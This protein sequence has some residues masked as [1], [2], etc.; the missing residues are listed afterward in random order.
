MGAGRSPC[1]A[2]CWRRARSRTT[3]TR[4]AATR[5]HRPTCPA[6]DPTTTDPTTGDPSRRPATPSRPCG[7]D[8]EVATVT[9]PDPTGLPSISE[10]GR[11]DRRRDARQRA[12]LHRALERQSRRPG[13]DAAGG[14]RRFGR[15]DRRPGRRGPFPRTHAVQRHRGVP[16]ER[17]HRHAAQLRGE[18]RRRRE[19][20]HELRRDGL[21]ADDAH[22]GPDRGR[23]RAADPRTMAG[24]GHARSGA[25]RGR[26]WRRA[27]RV[28][29]VGDEFERPHL[30]RARI[31]APRRLAVRGA[32]PDRHRH[33]DQRDDPRAAA[34]VLRHLVPPGQRVGRGGGRH[35]HGR[36]SSRGSRPSS[37]RSPPMVRCPTDPRC[38][39]SRRPRS[40]RRWSPIPMWRRDSRRS[41][42]RWSRP[43]RTIP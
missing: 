41:I 12:A 24:G 29:W 42:S 13:V 25:G 14:R 31:A 43:A 22:A 11:R 21:R 7:A 8:P 27:R 19:R 17:A 4:G 36:R 34:G 6:T 3:S 33:R 2:P 26:A 37:V 5:S 32:R 16:G 20:V 38:G 18:L 9:A 23:H 1:A 40:R 39:R 15:S 10:P 30:R 28:A 35:R